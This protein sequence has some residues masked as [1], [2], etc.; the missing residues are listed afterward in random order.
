MREPV[1]MIVAS[2]LSASSLLA[3]GG[4]IAAGSPPV[5]GAVVVPL[6]EFT[7]GGVTPVCASAGAVN[8]RANPTTA[9]ERSAVSPR[10]ASIFMVERPLLFTA[11]AAHDPERAN[12]PPTISPA[13]SM[14]RADV[15]AN[16]NMECTGANLPHFARAR[17]RC[18]ILPAGGLEG[19]PMFAH[20]PG[21]ALIVVSAATLAIVALL[22]V[23]WV[24]AAGAAILWGVRRGRAGTALAARAELLEGA[25]AAILTIAADGRLTGDPRVAD[26]LGLARLPRFM[27]DLAGETAGLV[28]ADADRLASAVEAA[29]RA[30]RSVAIDVRVAGSERVLAARGRAD[31]AGG[32]ALWLFDLSESAQEIARL[33]AETTRLSRAVESIAQLIEAAPLPMWHRGP[34]LRLALVNGAYVR[35]VEGRDAADVIARGLELVEGAAGR[36]P[37]AGAA[38]AH[39][40]TDPIVRTAPATVAGE[41]R[42]I[43]IVDVPLGLAG[44]A[45]YAIDVEE[46]EQ[47]RAEL[48]RFARAQREALDRLSAA[49]AQFGADRTLAFCNVPFTRLFAIDPDWVSEEPEFDRVLDRMREAGRAPESRD[50]PGWKAE[51][52]GWFVATEAIEETW[53]LPGGRHLRVLGQPLPDGGLLLIFEDR[54]EQVQLASARDTLLRVRTATFDN[55]FEAVGVFASDGRLHLWNNRFKDVWGMSEAELAAHPR[56][57][58]MVE[59]V[60]KRL[61]VPARASLIRDL[62]RIATIDRQQRSGRVTLADGRHFEFA[63]VPLPDGNAL[64]T[65]LDITASRTIEAALR[66]RTEAL[67]EADALKTAFVAN[68]SYELRVPLTSISGF[69]EL[70][71]A[72]YAGT[73]GDVAREYVAAI[74]TSTARLGTLVEDVLDLT[75]SAAGGIPL[76]DAQVDLT[77]L[78]HAA[79]EA[80]QPAAAAAGLALVLAVDGSVGSVTGDARRLRQALDHL[81][82]NAVA[83]TPRGGRVLFH[84]EGDA[85]WATL[86]V[87]DDGEGIAPAD[88]TRVFDRF[89]RGRAGNAG[90][91][92]AALGLGLPLTRQFVEAH[93]G[94]IALT[95]AAG[96]G[97][98]VTVRL[99]RRRV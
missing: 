97:T 38:S 65:M 11:I 86:V 84:A 42:M 96:E 3:A 5:G 27:G 32:L 82:R 30:G 80:A 12:L 99:P 92:R 21:P 46:L 74:L 37:L 18:S 48:G 68:M 20:S 2:V 75:Q 64:F 29:A 14:T 67:E 40:A 76:A 73:L 31:G 9:L 4:V 49:V 56:V 39:G 87:S 41:R 28:P 63:A 88:Q 25:P 34:D 43:R 58:A 19:G 98:T 54:T 79:G 62:V 81:L 17:R 33:D 57:D 55:L 13:L 23:A 6:G 77:A 78:A 85:E 69:A 36:G 59:A 7:S 71:E 47:A 90:D 1:T 44:V 50:F 16:L 52:R 60:A 10:R 83:Y 22:A 72:G 35:A 24:V 89:H 95:S 8:A 15:T 66:E 51:R 61:A 70:L 53:L 45:G 94:T 93:G 91:G 26:W